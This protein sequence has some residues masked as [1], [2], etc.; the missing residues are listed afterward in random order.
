MNT[1]VRLNNRLDP[2]AALLSHHLDDLFSG[3][4]RPLPGEARNNV[5]PIKIE[6]REDPSAYHVSAVIAGAKKEDIHIEVDQKEVS[7]LAEIKRENVTPVDV[8]QDAAKEAGRVLHSER[9]YGKTSR[10]FS[11]AQDIDEAAVEAK[12]AD[13]V[14]SLVLPKKV[15]VS[16]KRVTVQ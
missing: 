13:G 5:T 8:N 6:V 10:V 2:S 7:I 14:L 11:L 16:A 15:P 4:L 9:F 12:Y 1:L 3:F